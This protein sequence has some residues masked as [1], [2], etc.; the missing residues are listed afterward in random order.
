MIVK[1]KCIL[2]N[3]KYCVTEGCE[4]DSFVDSNDIHVI[5]DDCGYFLFIDLDDVNDGKWEIVK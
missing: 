5:K 3:N 1:L 4:Y 2:A